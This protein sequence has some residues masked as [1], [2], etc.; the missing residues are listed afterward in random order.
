MEIIKIFLTPQISEKEN[1]RYS[2][3]GDILTIK[4]GNITDEFDFTGLPDGRLEM[5]DK[6]GN[7]LIETT[8]R[9]NPL[10]KA[11]KKDGVLYLT[12]LNRIGI[13]ATYEEKF[14]EWIDAKDYVFKEADNGETE[15]E[16][17]EGS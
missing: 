3:E 14:P 4:E 15:L 7:E 8:L 2:F 6:E 12:L 17:S 9:V 16:K 10:I 5:Y 13:D 1:F 11:E